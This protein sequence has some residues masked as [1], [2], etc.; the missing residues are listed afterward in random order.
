LVE[1]TWKTIQNRKAES[2]I[3][4]TGVTKKQRGGPRHLVKNVE[5]GPQTSNKMANRNLGGDRQRA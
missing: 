2:C 4:K 5:K 1:G 3:V